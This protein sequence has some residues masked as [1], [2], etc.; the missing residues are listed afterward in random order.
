MPCALLSRGPGSLA[1]PIR[2]T[3]RTPRHRSKVAVEGWR[4]RL[5]GQRRQPP[6]GRRER[7]GCA[8]GWCPRRPG[9]AAMAECPASRCWPSRHP[10]ACPV[11]FNRRGWKPLRKAT[12]P[13]RGRCRARGRSIAPAP[14]GAGHASRMESY[15]VGVGAGAGAGVAGA[16]AGVAG[17]GAGSGAGAG[18]VVPPVVA[19]G[20]MV[21][22][23]WRP[24]ANHRTTTITIT[25]MMPITHLV[26]LVI[27]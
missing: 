5:D 27:F 26:V 2:P 17:A 16:G 14:I 13:A 8:I 24:K 9:R 15:G 21:S 3:S 10:I 22:A 23:P 12:L 7:A 25:T 11:T 18:V 6:G 1:N 4:Q 19:S 20:I